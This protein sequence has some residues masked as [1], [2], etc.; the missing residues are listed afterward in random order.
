VCR[1][2]FAKMSFFHVVAGFIW[3]GVAL[4]VI[5]TLPVPGCM[6]SL[7]NRFRLWLFRPFNYVCCA[8]SRSFNIKFV[9][10][11]FL[12]YLCFA[13]SFLMSLEH[14][15]SGGRLGPEGTVKKMSKFRKQRN[16]WMVAFGTVV[17]YALARI[18][19]LIQKYESSKT[20]A[21]AG[22][23]QPNAEAKTNKKPKDQ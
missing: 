23:T 3:F 1:I 22:Q 16:F 15:S 4:L 7:S 2:I 9:D 8:C 6:E 20:Q 11:L 19:S 21:P 10:V 17:Y 5:L 14:V 18:S 12:V 13:V